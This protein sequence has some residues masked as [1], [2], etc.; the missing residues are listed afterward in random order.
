VPI[1]KARLWLC[2]CSL[3]PSLSLHPEAQNMNSE[4]YD[5]ERQPK[6]TMC[7]PLRVWALDRAL[8]RLRR[9]AR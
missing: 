2:A 6:P 3:Q 7:R 1:R 8:D 5:P 4:I 9:T